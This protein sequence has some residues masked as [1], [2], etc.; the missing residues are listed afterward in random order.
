[1]ILIFHYG[2]VNDDGKAVTYWR[3][4]G[5]FPIARLPTV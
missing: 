2:Q 3:R 5:V 1:M 4:K